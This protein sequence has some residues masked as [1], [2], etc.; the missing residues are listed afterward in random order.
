VV[1]DPL[2]DAATDAVK[3]IPESEL[4][5]IDEKPLFIPF[6]GT[7]KQIPTRPYKGSDP[8]WQEFVKFS[9]NP[10]LGKSV[11]S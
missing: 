4:E 2:D 1:F 9:K 11:R 3:H 5:E 10:E 8:E 7:T 6:P